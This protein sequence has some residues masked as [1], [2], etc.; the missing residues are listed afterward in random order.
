L[1]LLGNLELKGR[2]GFK[3]KKDGNP[4]AGPKMQIK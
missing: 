2:G 1:K 4:I 3:K